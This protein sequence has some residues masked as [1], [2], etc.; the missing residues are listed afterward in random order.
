MRRSSRKS[1]PSPTHG[2][3]TAIGASAWNCQPVKPS[4]VA[5]FGGDGVDIMLGV[6]AET[7]GAA[8]RL[9]ANLDLRRCVLVTL[10]VAGVAPAIHACRYDTL[11]DGA[12]VTSPGESCALVA[13][14]RGGFATGSGMISA[15]I[16][17]KGLTSRDLGRDPSGAEIGASVQRAT[18]VPSPVGV[19]PAL[20]QW[21]DG[22]IEGVPD[23]MPVPGV[24]GRPALAIPRIDCTSG[25]ARAAISRPRSPKVNRRP[26]REAHCLNR[27][28]SSRRIEYVNHSSLDR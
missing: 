28:L 2:N 22:A 5:A 19:G 26:R 14:L 21:K 8:L 27:F 13:S 15:H 9:V 25:R 17:R 12:P 23:H 24:C 1:G 4:P 10:A 20:R 6:C 18:D 7:R 16:I 11:F 3:V